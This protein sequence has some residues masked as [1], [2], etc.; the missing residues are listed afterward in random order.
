MNRWFH[1][2]TGHDL[3]ATLELT[4]EFLLQCETDE[5]YWKWFVMALHSAAQNTASLALENGNGYLVQKPGTALRMQQAHACGGAPVEP[6]MDNFLKL[7]KRSLEKSNLRGAANPLPENGILAALKSVDDLRDGFAHFNVK[8]WAIEVSLILECA[9]AVAKYIDNYTV[10]TPAIL[11]S[12]CVLQA[13]AESAVTKL[14]S[15]L[16]IKNRMVSELPPVRW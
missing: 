11:W 16:L 9:M 8:S 15:Q 3:V 7:I 14:G 12:D 13:R 1:T 2:D 10:R 6:H 5:R 4:C